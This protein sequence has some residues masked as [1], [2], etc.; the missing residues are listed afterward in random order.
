MDQVH[1]LVVLE[2]DLRKFLEQLVFSFALGLDKQGGLFVAATLLD[3]HL[4]VAVLDG[5]DLLLGREQ[6]HMQFVILLDDL[7]NLVP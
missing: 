4:V 6:L 7:P 5:E 2:F 1:E 3:E